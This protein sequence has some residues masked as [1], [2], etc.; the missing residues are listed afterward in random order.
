MCSNSSVS[1]QLPCLSSTRRVSPAIANFTGVGMEATTVASKLNLAL[2]ALLIAKQRPPTRLPVH[3]PE[4]RL[5]RVRRR[6]RLARA[7]A[8]RSLLESTLTYQYYSCTVWEF[9][10]PGKVV[11][12]TCTG[13][14]THSCECWYSGTRGTLTGTRT[15]PPVLFV[16]HVL[17]S[18]KHISYRRLM[19]RLL[20]LSA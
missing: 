19:R 16:A 14:G 15:W 11:L 20:V 5:R 8:D 3:V 18:T 1:E 7:H 17:H 2:P 6:L 13:T 9:L 12:T 4:L 10:L